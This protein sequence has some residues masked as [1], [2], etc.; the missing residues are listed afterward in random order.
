MILKSWIDSQSKKIK[1]AHLHMIPEG[2]YKYE[3]DEFI[4]S[5]EGKA[6]RVEGFGIPALAIALELDGQIWKRFDIAPTTTA[7]GDTLGL[8]ALRSYPEASRGSGA[9]IDQMI[10][11]MSCAEE[12]YLDCQVPAQE[13]QHLFKKEAIEQLGVLKYATKSVYFNITYGDA[14]HITRPVFICD[15][16]CLNPKKSPHRCQ[17]RLPLRLKI[18]IS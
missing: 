11:T 14:P 4:F 1:V 6:Y 9:N 3:N 5:S 18:T 13:R 16:P 7:A 17:I 2:G 10:K 15:Q 8:H 12:G